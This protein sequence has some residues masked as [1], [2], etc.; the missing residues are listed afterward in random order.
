MKTRS[1]YSRRSGSV[2]VTTL[3][4]AMLVGVV[5]GA[6]LII[7]QQHNTLTARSQTWNREI[8]IAEAG[9]E[10]AM[11]HL[12]SKPATL[13]AN[14][15][16]NSGSNVVK[17]RV[18]GDGYYY[19][20]LSTQAQKPTIV[21]VGFGRI[22][23]QTNFTRRVV[24]AT[25]KLGVPWGFIGITGVDMGG[26]T[27]Y[28]DSYDSSD[29]RYSTNGLYTFSKRRDMVG[30][31]TLSSNNPAINTGTAKIY[32]YAATGPGGTVVGNVGDGTFLST[33]SGVQSGHA[34]DDFN[35]SIG[36]AP[37]PATDFTTALPPVGGTVN[38]TVYSYVLPS[39][40]ATNFK[41]LSDLTIGGGGG[42]MIVTGK[43]K[44]YVPGNFEIKGTGKLIITNGG[45]LE[46]YLAGTATVGG[47]GVVNATGVSTNFTLYG[48]TNCTSIKFMGGSEYTSR[49][50]APQA[51]VEIGGTAEFC[52]A[53][54]GLSLKFS[55]T[56]A[57]HYDEAMGGS[58]PTFKIIA[59]EE[60]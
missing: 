40:I 11:A 42:D 39:L 12:N 54:V 21:S 10:E 25:A 23:L 16:T 20:T 19:T 35:G 36:P 33:S 6:L 13:A 3:V 43:T 28:I 53:I 55:G 51:A 52:G 7:S 9:I 22:P 37:F 50:Y 48:L 60:L 44:L 57:L 41:M 15:W 26:T 5:V 32:G 30:I 34:S 27:T 18:L 38:G 24:T 46:L 45:S 59:W 29:P 2:L 58:S 8:P 17:S 47:Q 4:L 56:P 49:I 1:F 31:A 14:G